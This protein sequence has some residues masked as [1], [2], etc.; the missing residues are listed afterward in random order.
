[1][2]SVAVAVSLAERARPIFGRDPLRELEP[3][4]RLPGRW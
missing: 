3:L 2:S 4:A 1:L